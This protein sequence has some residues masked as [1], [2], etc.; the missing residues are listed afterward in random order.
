MINKNFQ[1]MLNKP[2][3]ELRKMEADLR[4]KFWKLSEDLKRGKVKNIR[5]IHGLKKDIARVL[6]AM[7]AKLDKAVK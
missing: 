2:V 3:E 6:T 7:N 4:D 1:E 5:E